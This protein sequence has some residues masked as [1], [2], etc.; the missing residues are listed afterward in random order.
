MHRSDGIEGRSTCFLLVVALAASVLAWAVPTGAWAAEARYG[1]AVQV[2]GEQQ[3]VVGSDYVTVKVVH[4][5]FNVRMDSTLWE[6]LLGKQVK[7]ALTTLDIAYGRTRDDKPLTVRAPLT[8]VRVDRKHPCGA[9]W[10]VY[11]T[12]LLPVNSEDRALRIACE[13]RTATS[14]EQSGLSVI[15][16]LLTTTKLSALMPAGSLVSELT[17]QAQETAA[18]AYADLGRKEFSQ[19]STTDL[20]L[21]PVENGSDALQ[22]RF[23]R[24]VLFGDPVLTEEGPPDEYVSPVGQFEPETV[25]DL[26]MAFAESRGAPVDGHKLPADSGDLYNLPSYVLVEVEVVRPLFS[27]ADAL[28]KGGAKGALVREL[29][30]RLEATRARLAEAKAPESTIRQDA[31]ELGAWLKG[32]DALYSGADI[33]YVVAHWLKKLPEGQGEPEWGAEAEAVAQDYLPTQVPPPQQ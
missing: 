1:A 7:T 17:R 12:P 28:W 20:T 9:D 4:Q 18:Q 11:V 32:G 2:A 24:F 31:K 25:E 19:L 6:F 21:S 26:G 13:M 33:A 16:G 5:R 10:G 14:R 3:A 22:V 30:A 27:V 15:G 8:P 23:P 29:D